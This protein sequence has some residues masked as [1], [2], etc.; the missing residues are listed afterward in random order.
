MAAVSGV[1]GLLNSLSAKDLSDLAGLGSD[2]ARYNFLWSRANSQQR[3][4]LDTVRANPELYN[5]LFDGWTVNIGM[6][7]C[8]RV[9][10]CFWEWGGL[11]IWQKVYN[12]S[13]KV[14]FFANNLSLLIS[15]YKASGYF[16][17][18]FSK[19]QDRKLRFSLL[20]RA[21]KNASNHIC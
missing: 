9:P 16:L 2:T 5:K 3:K 8:S 4:H 10:D 20:E 19:R 1:R 15:K 18:N 14:D 17:N 12:F 7:H 13:Q 21:D 11:K 6:I